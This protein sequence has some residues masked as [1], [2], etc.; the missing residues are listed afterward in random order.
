MALGLLAGTA[1]AQT[2]TQYVIEQL[3]VSVN[4]TTDGSGNRVGQI[5]SG[6]HVEVLER[7]GEQTRVRTASGEEG[8]VRTSYLSSTPPLR[9]QLKARTDELEKL[10]QEK[11]KLESDLAGARK[12]LSAATAADAASSVAPSST[13]S[14]SSPSPS[15]A[16]ETRPAQSPPPE[17]ASTDA[18][19]PSNPP[20]FSSEGMMPS[21]PSWLVALIA[22]VATLGIGFALGWRMLDRRIRAK[23]GG[24]RIY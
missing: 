20:L 10:R 15:A 13:A 5:K 24:L 22:S 12:S 6:D 19:P 3:V 21:R 8:W 16:A 17:V 23:Y 2:E 9:D 14:D 11:T 4:A 18:A 1:A 7:Q